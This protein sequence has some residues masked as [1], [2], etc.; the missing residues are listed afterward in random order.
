[1]LRK[2]SKDTSIKTKQSSRKW[3]NYYIDNKYHFITGSVGGY[4]PLFEHKEYSINVVKEILKS[5]EVL[6]TA[7]VI[8]PEHY[9]FLLWHE[10]G[11]RIQK[12]MQTVLSQSSSK[13]LS[14]IKSIN[15]NEIYQWKYARKNNVGLFLCGE[16]RK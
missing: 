16:V 14:L 11:I 4:L 7:W 2:I 15:S 3:E 6:M 13:L 12:F 5:Y 1:M 9:H 8:M 10:S